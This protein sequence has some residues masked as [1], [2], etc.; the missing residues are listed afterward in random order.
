[1]AGFREPTRTV[2]ASVNW[3]L[4]QEN[5]QKTYTKKVLVMM[6]TTISSFH[7]NFY[8]PEL[9]ELHLN[10]V[11]HFKMFYVALIMMRG[12]LLVFPTKYN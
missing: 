10:A 11:N 5:K 3:I 6:E 9:V 12:Y 2:V 8:I 4:I 7:T 1:M